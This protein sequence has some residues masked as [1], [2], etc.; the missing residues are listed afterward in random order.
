MRTSSAKAKGRRLCQKVRDTLLE[1][2]PDLQE[3]DI[4]ITS[5]GAPGEDLLLSPKAQEV[6]P[7]TFECKNH[8]RIQIWVAYE[9]AKQHAAE[10]G[11]MPV[12]V[13]SKN[14]EEPMITMKLDHW[15]KLVR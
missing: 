14:R 13:F 3:G 4:R 15:L 12:V 11:L 9:Q 6:Y 7:V 5:S 10:T 1:W 2:A 8:E